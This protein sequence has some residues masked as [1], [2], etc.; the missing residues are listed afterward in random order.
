MPCFVLFFFNLIS[1]L[2]KPF[3]RGLGPQNTNVVDGS[4]LNPEP[5]C[6]QRVPWTSTS[7]SLNFSP[8]FIALLS[9]I[10]SVCVSE[11]DLAHSKCLKTIPVII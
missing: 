4:E 11:D 5:D 10:T 3:C 8:S 7:L 9:V 6:L 2:E 1:G